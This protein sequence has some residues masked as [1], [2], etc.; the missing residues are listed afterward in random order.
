MEKYEY[1]N[2][3]TL[4]MYRSAPVH[5]SLRPSDEKGGG[6][7]YCKCDL[8]QINTYFSNIT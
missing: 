1:L 5:L 3:N 6:P 7:F 2:M 8:S 4:Q